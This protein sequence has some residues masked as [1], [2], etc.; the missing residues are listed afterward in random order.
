MAKLKLLLV[1]VII[2]SIFII[3]ANAEAAAAVAANSN[4]ASPI[5]DILGSLVNNIACRGTSNFGR[6]GQCLPRSC[7]AADLSVERLCI[8]GAYTC[9]Y[10]RDLCIDRDIH[11]HDGHNRPLEDGYR[12]G[13]ILHRPGGVHRPS[14]SNDRFGGKFI[15]F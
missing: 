7:C 14:I 1:F 5:T 11:H 10:G 6:T 13:G 9:C 3:T 4:Q 2:Q 12:P 8:D 15:V